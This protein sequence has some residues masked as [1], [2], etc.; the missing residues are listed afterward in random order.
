MAGLY[1]RL[2]T[3]SRPLH[4][5][6][7]PPDLREVA[8][9]VRLNDLCFAETPHVQPCEW[10]E[11]SCENAAYLTSDGRTI[12]RIPEY[13]DGRATPEYYQM[14]YAQEA[15]EEYPWLEGI[16]IEPPAGESRD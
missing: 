12:R 15:G 16:T 13:A 2:L 14:W 1:G 10:G 11:V 8:L 7:L 4:I 3:P 5:D 9:R 6:Q